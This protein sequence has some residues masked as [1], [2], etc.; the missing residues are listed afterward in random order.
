MA[1]LTVRVKGSEGYTR[2][3]LGKDRTVVGRASSCDVVVPTNKLSREH[4]LLVRKDDGWWI[5]DLN[6]S[7]GTWINTERIGGP[8]KLKEK[9]VVKAGAAR[10]TFHAGELDQVE[11]IEVQ[12]RATEDDAAD[13]DAP[14]D[15]LAAAAACP[16]CGLWLS[17]AHRQR[18]Q[19]V[20]C[21]RCS[22]AVAVP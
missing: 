20:T 12:A 5:E 11:A 3:T 7:N 13:Q 14:V 6:S 15:G 9:D 1:F 10:L 21:P 19:A 18:G 22:G 8:R 16:G 2:V 17:V 4:C